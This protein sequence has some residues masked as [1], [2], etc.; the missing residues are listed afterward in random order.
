M[1][2][3]CVVM[4]RKVPGIILAV[5]KALCCC[6]PFVAPTVAGRI[7]GILSSTRDRKRGTGR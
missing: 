3:M 2:Q 5:F 1:N 6:E 7:G 4:I